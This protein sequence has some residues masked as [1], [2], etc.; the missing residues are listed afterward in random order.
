MAFFPSIFKIVSTTLAGLP[1]AV[2]WG[3]VRLITDSVRGLW[4]DVPT[5]GWVATNRPCNVQMWGAKSDGK[6]MYGSI[7][8]SSTTLTRTRGSDIFA[9]ADVGRTV[10][11]T[12]AG[13]AGALLTTT[14]SVFTDSNTVTL[15]ASASTTVTGLMVNVRGTDDG[16]AVEAAYTAGCRSVFLP[17]GTRFVP[18]V[19]LGE[20]CTLIGEN[21]SSVVDSSGTFFNIGAGATVQNV[22]IKDTNEPGGA[23]CPLFINRAT[24]Q[25][26]LSPANHLGIMVWKGGFTGDS[27]TGITSTHAGI[28]SGDN[29]YAQTT[30]ANDS[31]TGARAT[32]YNTALYRGDLYATA[33]GGA[34]VFEGFVW[35]S[36]N[37]TGADGSQALHI[38]D[39]RTGSGEDGVAL[40]FTE[41]RTDTD[42]LVVIKHS[43]GAYGGS[44]LEVRSESAYTGRQVRIKGNSDP[45]G[46]QVWSN[47]GSGR[48]YALV[49][50][51]DGSS[52][53]QEDTTGA[54]GMKLTSGN[55]IQAFDGSNCREIDLTTGL[56]GTCS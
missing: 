20:G 27:N 12:G 50:E 33:S 49:S 48:V 30:Q 13:V 51:T 54:V 1:A 36:P 45:A 37:G 14:I 6:I 55:K 29:F 46:L 17:R 4:V 53:W 39:L 47:G 34:H 7:S 42:P 19:A 24:R 52:K 35:G 40:F 32:E 21:E 11:V 5:V 9:A 43:A 56:W 15:A 25:V 41:T 28:G 26:T 31:D 23:F 16:A 8:S 18:T 10:T 22:T 38:K 2:G 44:L 3:P